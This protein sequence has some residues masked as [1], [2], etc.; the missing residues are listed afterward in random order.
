VTAKLILGGVR[1]IL[2]PRPLLRHDVTTIDS[3]I[4]LLTLN[5]GV[6]VVMHVAPLLVH[7]GAAKAQSRPNNKS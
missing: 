4:L 6:V 3:Q 2:L 7:L 1:Y 5:V